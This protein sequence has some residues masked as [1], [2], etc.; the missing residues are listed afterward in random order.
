MKKKVLSLVLAAVMVLGMTG[1]ATSNQSAADAG[2]TANTTGEAAV[3]DLVPEPQKREKPLHIAYVNAGMNTYYSLIL[4]GMQEELERYGN[5]EVG[6]IDVYSPTNVSKMVE[7]QIGFLETLLQD[8]TLD[9][10]CFSTHN[11]TEFIPYLKQFCEKGVS[12]YLFNMPAQ[13][14]SNEYYVSLVSY[15]FTE[16]GRLAGQW[17]KDNLKDEAVKMLYLEGQE[18]SHNTIRTEGFMEGI[19]GADNIEIVVS[20]PADWTRQGGQEVTENALQSN[21]EIN[22]IYGPY[23]E[24]PLGAIVALKDAGKLDG[25]TVV[26]YDCT[27]DGYNAILNGEMAASVNTDAKQMGSNMIDTIIAH[28]LEGKEVER[29]I[30]N[31]LTVIDS[32]NTD[33][34]PSDNYSYTEQ[35]KSKEVEQ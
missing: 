9:V 6:T 30:M 22:C 16:A 8:D 23:D 2:A 18:G 11:D 1:C 31:E 26:G 4:N 10:L 19:E 3:S 14:V 13:D 25:T 15:D 5:E 21:P 33:L 34:I 17:I 24:M 27:E 35:K 12:V 20:Q 28:D 7:E 29:A 32:T